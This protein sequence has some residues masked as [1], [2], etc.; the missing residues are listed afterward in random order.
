M[1]RDFQ[2]GHHGGAVLELEFQSDGHAIAHDNNCD[3]RMVG[4]SMG[5]APIGRL[6]QKTPLERRSELMGSCRI[7][8]NELV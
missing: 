6:A 1:L 4:A 3:N 8:K 2:E 7:V 5:R